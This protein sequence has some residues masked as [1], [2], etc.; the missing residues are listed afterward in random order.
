MELDS[1]TG[2]SQTMQPYPPL[3]PR[4]PNE[5]VRLQFGLRTLL[6]IVLASGP[7]LLLGSAVRSFLLGSSAS[8][9]VDGLRVALVVGL[10]VALLGAVAVGTIRLPGQ[11][12]IIGV[13]CLLPLLPLG[14]WMIVDVVMSELDREDAIDFQHDGQAGMAWILLC[15]GLGGIL[16][17][18]LRIANTE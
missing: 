16:G 10:G 13:V 14:G 12:A 6:I 4:R 17:F 8:E 11:V 3:P 15:V 2:A 5:P 9:L 7:L 1:T 18:I